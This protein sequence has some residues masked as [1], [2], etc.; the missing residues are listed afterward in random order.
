MAFIE[1]LSKV[2]FV[3]FDELSSS[4]MAVACILCP[5]IQ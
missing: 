5:S 3:S 1:L 2:P 4:G